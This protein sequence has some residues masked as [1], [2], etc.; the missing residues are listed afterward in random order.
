AYGGEDAGA[1]P[2]TAA[3]PPGLLAQPAAKAAARSPAPVPSA[4]R[5]RI[6]AL[7]PS[8]PDHLAFHSVPGFPG[9]Q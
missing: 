6:G 8:I 2:A 3:G 7:R 4:L 5:R 9:T 1:P